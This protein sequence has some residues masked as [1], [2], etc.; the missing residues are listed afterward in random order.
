MLEIGRADYGRALG[1]FRGGARHMKL[2]ALA[3]GTIEARVFVDAIDP[4]LTVVVYK[5]KL[6]IASELSAKDAA[7]VLRPFFADL[8][9]A[10]RMDAGVG[11]A[12]IYWDSDTALDACRLAL[13]GRLPVLWPRE[14]YLLHPPAAHRHVNAPEGYEILP[15]DAALLARGLEYT[16]ALCEEM[17]SE[18]SDVDAF[19]RHSF[20]VCAVKDGALAGWCLSEYNCT[21]GCEIGIE[22]GWKHRRRGLATAMTAALAQEADRCGLPA[23]GWHCYAGNKA[24][25]ATARSAGFALASGYGELL[26]CVDTAMQYA[27]NGIKAMADGRH[28]DAWEW[29]DKA[30]HDPG[31]Q[32]WMHVR[33]A[34]ACAAIDEADTAFDALARALEMDV[35][36]RGW[37]L[38]EPGLAGLHGDSRWSFGGD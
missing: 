7:V 23:I 1:L 36:L 31:A 24:S 34:M 2:K 27:S 17:C 8:I 25:A 13:A 18:R 19:L 16:D 15:V 29:F 37:I 14:H 12:V 28:R 9:Y 3:E 6:L 32:G 5:N 38:N 4:F 33:L 22:V 20:G 11:D 35:N 30:I 10:R 21:D 26:C